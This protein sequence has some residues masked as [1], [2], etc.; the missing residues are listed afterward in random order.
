MWE[1]VKSVVGGAIATIFIGG[2]AFVQCAL[3]FF[4]DNS[5]TWTCDSDGLR[6]FC[7]DEGTLANFF[8]AMCGE[9]DLTF[10]GNLIQTIGG[11][12]TDPDELELLVKCGSTS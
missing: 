5:E 12:G 8:V 10:K 2:I 3:P 7:D 11:D 6:Q 1:R 4:R 9:E